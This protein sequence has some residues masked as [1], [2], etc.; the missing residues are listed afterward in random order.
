MLVRNLG[1]AVAIA[2]GATLPTDCHAQQKGEFIPDLLINDVAEAQIAMHPVAPIVESSSLAVAEIDLTKIDLDSAVDWLARITGADPKSEQLAMP[3]LMAAG[4]LQTLRSAGAEKVYAA[5]SLRS[6]FD[7]GPVVII[8]CDDTEIVGGI[9]SMILSQQQSPDVWTMQTRGNSV[10]AG[11]KK[12]IERILGRTTDTEVE[13]RGALVRPLFSG[14]RLDHTLVLALPTEQRGEL[15]AFWP[16]QM[17]KASPIQMSPRQM[18][19]DV[20]RI[21]L[22][23]DLPPEPNLHIVLETADIAAAVRV[24]D[25]IRSCLQAAP[26]LEPH[27]TLSINSG[28]V[29]I[30]VAPDQIRAVITTLI[31]PIQAKGQQSQDVKK[32]KQI[33]LALHNYHSAYKSLPAPFVTDDDG[34]PLLSWR[35]TLLPMMDQT[36]LHNQFSQSDAWDSPVNRLLTKDSPYGPASGP[37]PQ[38][39]R[40]RAPVFP[41]SVW[42]DAQA[43]KRFRDVL[44]GLSNTIGLIHVPAADSVIWTRPKPWIVSVDDPVASV[45]GDR[46]TATVLMLDGSVRV[47]S[48]A[49]TSAERLKALLTI[50]GQERID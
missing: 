2:A 16:D 46:E 41:G 38:K 24:E 3:Q 34:N 10:I 48:K 30:R 8:P 12:A 20:N 31:A 37:E 39:T 42:D 9:L 29:E 32:L 50:N 18:V 47:L 5:A 33:G 43:G 22:S 4:V 40:F 27:V 28:D 23:F 15:Q 17:P 19:Q 35:M 21:L 49:D 14:G 26:Q 7:G 1:L 44:D 13:A 6:Y 25:V 45:F 11:S 36:E